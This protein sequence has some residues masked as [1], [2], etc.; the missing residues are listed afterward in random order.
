MCVVQTIK[1]VA[2]PSELGLGDDEMIRV[3]VFLNV[4]NVHVNRA[5]ASGKILSLNYHPVGFSMLRLIKQAFT[6]SVSLF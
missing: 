4:F 5:P 3:S 6:T 1:E 2:P